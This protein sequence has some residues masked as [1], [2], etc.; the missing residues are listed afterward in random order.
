MMPGRPAGDAPATRD[1]FTVLLVV[2]Y[3]AA[4]GIGLFFHEPWRD[5]WQA[6]LLARESESLP[7]L[8]RATR[9]E[10][11]PA[12]WHV[13][14]F[15]LARFT[16]SIVA[17]QALHLLIAAGAVWI[18]ARHAPFS[19]LQKLLL[20]FGYLPAYE[21]AVI[22]R[23]YALGTLALF[24]ACAAWDV[25]HRSPLPLALWLALLAQSSIYGVILALAFASAFVADLV[26][27]AAARGRA[28]ASARPFLLAAALVFA[29]LALAVQHATPPRDA[30]FTGR[31]ATVESETEVGA[32]R[33]V[34]L[35]PVRALVPFP[36]FENGTPVWGETLLVDE[37][38]IPNIPVLGILIGICLLPFVLRKPGALVLLVAGSA[39]LLLFAFGFHVG[40]LRH[41]GQLMLVVMAAFWLARLPGPVLPLLRGR[42]A[43]WKRA[44]ALGD[45]VFTLLLAAHTVT[46]ATL[47]VADLRLPFSP[48]RGAARVLETAGARTGVP[49]VATEAA[50]AT[51][52]AGHLDTPIHYLDAQATGTWVYWPWERTPVPGDSIV[53]RAAALLAPDVPAVLLVTTEP[54]PASAGTPGIDVQALPADPRPHL[55]PE[56]LFLYRVTRASGG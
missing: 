49:I 40:R 24:G 39:G 10:G 38:P 2:A 23:N 36:R 28:R 17:M 4:V 14:L 19:R 43:L 18:M 25:R 50:Y 34:A 51:S 56:G 5:E 15:G 22:S 1:G 53:P 35:M 44:R 29:S 8:F 9:Y 45:G 6:W 41:Q 16:R 37:G 20:A 42:E 12:A 31:A 33:S 48:A 52:L 13:L 46:F 27:D 26:F 11:A 3:I 21:Y 55:A 47:Y 30:A 54:L 7:E 32:L